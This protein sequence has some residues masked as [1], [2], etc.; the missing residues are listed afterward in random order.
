MI[1]NARLSDIMGIME[2]VKETIEEMHCNNNYQW[3]ENYPLIEDFTK[4]IE[5]GTL[6]V[7]EVEG[8]VTGFICINKEEPLEYKSINWALNED[9]FIIHRMAVRNNSRGTG[10]GAKLIKFADKIS[11]E[12]KI[13]YIKT[14]T[15]SLNIKAQGL[16]EK[17]GY[18][19]TGKMNFLGKE[20]SFYCYERIM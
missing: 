3:D 1:R 8:I 12:N 17:C 9:A 10:I 19:F 14:D 2:I 18:T 15:Y 7:F 16:L 13:A 4:D 11:A 20:K 6:S 5:A